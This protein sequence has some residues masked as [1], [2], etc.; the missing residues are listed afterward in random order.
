M[1][2]IIMAVFNEEKY[3]RQAIESILA[4][5]YRD[6]E[7]IV[8]NDGSTDLTQKIIMELA[9]SDLRMKVINLCKVG[10]NAAFNK[11]IAISSGNWIGLFAGDD[12]MEPG[13]LEDL[14]VVAR[15]YEPTKQKVVIGALQR[16]FTDDP[17]YKF[18]NDIV[19]PFKNADG[20]FANTVGIVSVSLCAAAFPVPTSYPNE[21]T[22]LA[23]AYRY[24]SDVRVQ[25]NLIYSNY[26]IHANNSYD[27]AS[28]DFYVYNESY[29]KRRIAI[30]EFCDTY[31]DCLSANQKLILSRLYELE[32]LRYNG[33]VIKL[34]LMGGVPYKEKIKALFFSN[35]LLNLI[36]IK[37]SRYVL[38]RI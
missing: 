22:W 20:I 28:H 1:I 7:L 37:L 13:V 15:K 3:V 25:T 6:L 29:H 5:S 30:K 12:I 4:Q 36:K 24:L 10:K 21:D 14:M 33:K 38:G 27:H 32:M 8:V 31:G 35:S 18:E 2:S 9:L 26:R 16:M 23:L 11:G 34:L 17:K 19:V